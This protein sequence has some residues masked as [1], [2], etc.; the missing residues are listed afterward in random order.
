MNTGERIRYLRIKNN[1]TS[2]ELSKALEISE[3]SISLYENGKRKPSIELLIKFSSYFNVSTDFLLGVEDSINSCKESGTDFS[4]VLQNAISLLNTQNYI[5]F[6]GK[7]VDNKTLIV[8]KNNLNC[9]LE[10]MR[11][12]TGN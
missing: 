10:N 12:M 11:M 7:D 8:I 4:K 9:L 5:I 2:K 1:L 6:E 3:S